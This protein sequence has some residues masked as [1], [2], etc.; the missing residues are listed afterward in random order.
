M[1]LEGHRKIKINKFTNCWCP[2]EGDE[3]EGDS[4]EDKE[5][6]ERRKKNLEDIGKLNVNKNKSSPM[7]K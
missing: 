1:G 6:N 4:C 2:A 3:D 7:V 5:D